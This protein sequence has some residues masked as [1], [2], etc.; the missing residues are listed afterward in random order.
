MRARNAEWHEAAPLSFRSLSRAGMLSAALPLV[1]SLVWAQV[2]GA[3]D[4][5]AHLSVKLRVVPDHAE[6]AGEGTGRDCEERADIPGRADDGLV[7]LSI[8]SPCRAGEVVH[9][10][11]EHVERD[12]RLDGQGYLSAVIPVFSDPALIRWERRD[13]RDEEARVSVPGLP[14]VLK[15]VL[16]WRGDLP[17]SLHV[18]EA[19]LRQPASGCGWVA[20]GASCRGIGQFA[21]LL[22]GPGRNVDVYTIPLAALP[23][24]GRLPYQV[25]FDPAA[26]DRPGPRDR[27]CGE[28]EDAAPLFEVWT[29]S[30]GT[31]RIERRGGFSTL[32]CGQGGLE[33]RISRGDIPLAP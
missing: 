28:G 16:T 5:V 19:I 1:L 3:A 11:T 2:H 27:Y 31:M 10:R 22:G 6:P 15:I 8:R 24:R 20:R 30:R 29:V 9:I 33:R 12:V 21:S 13:G 23:P 14:Q 25:V 4:R 18:D 17:L 26:G 32:P 7:A